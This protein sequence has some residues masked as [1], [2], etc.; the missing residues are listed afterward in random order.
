[1]LILSRLRFRN[2]DQVIAFTYEGAPGSAVLR[3]SNRYR[4]LAEILYSDDPLKATD[5]L[6]DSTA[7]LVALDDAQVL[8]PIDQQEVWVAETAKHVPRGLA[9]AEKWVAGIDRPKIRPELY[10]KATPNRVN[11]PDQ[12]LRLRSDSVRSVPEP[13][14]ALVVSP[15]GKLVGYSI[16]TGICAS[17]IVA[18]NP[19]YGPQ[20]RIFNGCCALGPHVLLTLDPLDLASTSISMEILRGNERVFAASARLDA[21]GEPFSDL[22]DWLFRDNSFPNG[23]V[24]LTGTGLISVGDFSLIHDD[25][26]NVSV[27]GLG[28]LSNRVAQIG[29]AV[30]HAMAH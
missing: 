25:L 1:M 9:D 29:R 23:V 30:P 15:R 5:E 16:A 19:C 24:L 10:L 14:L 3:P 20:A 27:T 4:N 12:P 2:G 7:T 18:E 13:G 11:G 8:S 17:D 28:T 6:S 22:I 26:V 21:I